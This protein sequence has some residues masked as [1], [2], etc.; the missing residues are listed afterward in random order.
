VKDNFAAVLNLKIMNTKRIN[1]ERPEAS[2]IQIKLE[3][4]ICVSKYMQFGDDNSSGSINDGSIIN[5][6]S[7]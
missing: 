3:G 6:G 4:V 2:V 7:F 5:G 1:Y